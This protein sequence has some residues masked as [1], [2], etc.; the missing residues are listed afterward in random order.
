MTAGALVTELA[1]A[2]VLGLWGGNQLD[3]LLGTSPLF[4]FTLTAA[5]F[6]GGLVIVHRAF[7]K[8]QA[9]SDEPPSDPP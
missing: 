2:V 4:L 8:A 3:G 5:G 1:I 6:V 7:A 9:S